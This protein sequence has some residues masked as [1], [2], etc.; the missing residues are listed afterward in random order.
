MRPALVVGVDTNLCIRQFFVVE[1]DACD[2]RHVVGE[3]V[4]VDGS[5]VAFRCHAL[6]AGLGNLRRCGSRRI[7]EGTLAVGDAVEHVSLAGFEQRERSC[8]FVAV[9]GGKAVLAL[10]HV[11]GFRLQA[12]KGIVERNHERVVVCNPVPA[13]RSRDCTLRGVGH[14]ADN[15]HGSRCGEVE[16]VHLAVVHGDYR[17][18]PA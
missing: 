5:E 16:F 10:H 4:V 9:V 17:S 11:A 3:S 7:G 12:C 18:V 13:L 8:P 1:G 15:L 6:L 14:L 2:E